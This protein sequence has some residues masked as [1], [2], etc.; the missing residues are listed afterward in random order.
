[1]KHEVVFEHTGGFPLTQDTL[2]F[3]QKNGATFADLANAIS[4]LQGSPYLIISG[5]GETEGGGIL[6]GI[7]SIEGAVLPFKGGAAQSRVKITESRQSDFFMDKV[8]REIYITRFAEFTEQEEDSFEWSAF[9]RLREKANTSGY[10]PLLKAGDSEKLGGRTW[11]DYLTVDDVE[12][13]MPWRINQLKIFS[14]YYDYQDPKF[15]LCDGSIVSKLDY[16]ELLGESIFAWEKIADAVGVVAIQ[17]LYRNYLAFGKYVFFQGEDI[18]SSDD[19]INWT[20]QPI[21]KSGSFGYSY[22]SLTKFGSRWVVY[23][24]Q[25]YQTKYSDND[26]VTWA[27]MTRPVSG[28]YTM[29]IMNNFCYGNNISAVVSGLS[30]IN[31]SYAWFSMDLGNTWTKLT[32]END[33]YVVYMAFLNG[34][35]L[36]GTKDGKLCITTDFDFRN[37]EYIQ[38]PHN[39]AVTQIYYDNGTY[40][41]R[42]ADGVCIS[43][44]LVNWTYFDKTVAPLGEYYFESGVWGVVGTL[45]G[46]NGLNL[47]TDL[48]TWEKYEAGIAN[49]YY[50]EPGPLIVGNNRLE[51]KELRLDR[52]KIP[53]ITLSGAKCYV[54][55]L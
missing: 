46:V 33:P 2:A 12:Q 27:A 55:A 21:N 11:E 15:L 50:I 18:C 42:S 10:Y 26:R 25:A 54:K 8:E 47:S 41:V 4:Q 34:K 3:M 37:V 23:T 29:N 38:L 44:D 16:P 22:A 39:G 14:E 49:I 28:S 1:M 31:A 35:F 30:T 24:G 40:I 7:V 48:I 17:Q 51:I 5:C 6:P 53:N 52:L 20:Q 13:L 19:G 36:I 32:L 9:V 43:S 45:N